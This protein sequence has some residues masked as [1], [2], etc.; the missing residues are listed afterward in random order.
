[1]LES[2]GLVPGGSPLATGLI[3]ALTTVRVPARSPAQGGGEVLH[4][5]EAVLRVLGE[6]TLQGR[7]DVARHVGPRLASIGGGGSKTCL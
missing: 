5:G 1:M 4:G 6:R 7:A 2:F 3:G